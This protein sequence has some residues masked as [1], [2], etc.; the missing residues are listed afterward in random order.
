LKFLPFEQAREFVHKLGLAKQKEWYE[1]CK[2]K[3]KPLNIPS[4]AS[5]V[6]RKEWKSWGD[7]LGTE[8]IALQNRIYLPFEEARKYVRKL[9]LKNGAE[10]SA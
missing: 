4:N 3:D 8:Y 7:W 9:A 10:W 1:Y 2:S 6:Y 5:H